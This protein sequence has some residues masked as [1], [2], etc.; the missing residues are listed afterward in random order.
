[1]KHRR[2]TIAS[3]LALALGLALAPTAQAALPPG[4]SGAWYN[5][6][7]SGHG[8][9]LQVIAPDR[10][11]VFWYL[12]DTEG[13]PFFLYMDGRIEGR[14]IE[15]TALAPTGLRFG[16]FDRSDFAMPEWGTVVIEFDDC[17]RGLLHWDA[18]S[19]EFGSG[20]TELRRLTGIHA[21]ECVLSAEPPVLQGLVGIEI[22]RVQGEAAQGFPQAGIGA[23]D[24]D[25][26]IWAIEQGSW[27]DRSPTGGYVGAMP[28]VALGSVEA[29]PLEG[30]RARL[31]EWSNT[32]TA[33]QLDGAFG[34]PRG[35]WQ[36]VAAL[37]PDTLELRN[38]SAW[39]HRR[40]QFA[41]REGAALVAPLSLAGVSREYLVDLR[42]QFGDVTVPL[43]VQPDGSICLG[44]KDSSG[45]QTE[46]CGLRGRLWL[47]EPEAGFFDFELVEQDAPQSDAYRGRGWLE[48]RSEGGRRLV[49]VGSNGAR[50]LGVVAR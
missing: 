8:L 39:E 32:W 33:T 34:C 22:D 20:S 42:W 19:P 50:G 30:L 25:G 26:R 43:S 23:I 5:P 35:A 2:C 16:S 1:M 18:N 31:S 14:R 40:W 21:S 38:S 4:L 9:S 37:Q 44:T 10:A 41:A 3:P 17:N 28:C 13:Q 27:P 12:Y 29:L 15:A 36:G 45:T 48:E 49:L 11:L 6:G 46:A 47:T 7:Q 24:P